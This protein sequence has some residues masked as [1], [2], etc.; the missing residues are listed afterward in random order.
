MRLCPARTP[1]LTEPAETAEDLAAACC[2]G[3]FAESCAEGGGK[4]PG[5]RSKQC[6]VH[7]GRLLY[8]AFEWLG[9]GICPLSSPQLFA[10]VHLEAV[11]L[12]WGV[13]LR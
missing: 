7:M 5:Y 12:F 10:E 13:V 9:S 8:A 2:F 11:C 1:Q 4:A 6:H 3:G